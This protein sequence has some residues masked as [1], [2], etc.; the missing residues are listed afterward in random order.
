MAERGQGGETRRRRK[1]RNE[2][3]KEGRDERRKAGWEEGDSRL[4]E[5]FML[6]CSFI[7]FRR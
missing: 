2:R 1:R 5:M 3:G 6:I 4:K 7:I